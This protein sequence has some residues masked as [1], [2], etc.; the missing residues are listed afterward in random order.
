[1]SLS[2]RKV[3]ESRPNDLDHYISAF[4]TQI[5][6]R[7]EQV[8]GTSGNANGRVEYIGYAPPDALLSQPA[9]QIKKLIYD[10]DGFNTQILFANGS[11]KFNLVFNS[12][13]SEYDDY[14]YIST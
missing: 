7:V 13:V 1:M 6:L 3:R 5:L 12:G 4:P 14:T 10:S 8:K 11:S 2:E 9:W